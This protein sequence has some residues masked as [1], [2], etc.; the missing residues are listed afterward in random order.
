MLSR[1][2]PWL[3][4][5]MRR[6]DAGTSGAVSVPGL[7]GGC[8]GALLIG[9]SGAVWDGGEIARLALIAAVAG[10][11]GSFVDSLLGATLQVQYA[12]ARCGLITERRE[13]CGSP[14]IRSRGPAWLTNDLVNLACTLS[15]AIIGFA[16]SRIWL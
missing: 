11:A 10:T 16:L 9:V 12:C 3:L 6:V 13:H 1:S 15:G 4:A 2:R 7:V 8:A 5:A 14:T